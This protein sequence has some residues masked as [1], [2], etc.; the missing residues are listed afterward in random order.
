MLYP[1]STLVA[2]VL[3]KSQA[4]PCKGIETVSVPGS[5]LKVG[6]S[7]F[8][9]SET[10]RIRERFQ[11]KSGLYALIWSLHRTA[12]LFYATDRFVGWRNAH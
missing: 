11:G 4:M 3:A 6:I 2:S 10:E 1:L 9:A 12:L 8:R 5:L 7:T